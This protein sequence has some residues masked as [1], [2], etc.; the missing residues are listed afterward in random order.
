[1]RYEKRKNWI[2]EKKNKERKKYQFRTILIKNKQQNKSRTG[3]LINTAYVTA[4]KENVE[5]EII[6]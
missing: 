3:Y 1:M 6:Y 4:Q 5:L 2:R